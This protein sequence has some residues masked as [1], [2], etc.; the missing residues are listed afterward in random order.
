MPISQGTSYVFNWPA[1][2]KALL[3]EK[4]LREVTWQLVADQTGVH[5]TT[6]TRV[7]NSGKT[8]D[9]N[10]VL[11]LCK[12]MNRNPFD[13]ATRK[14]TAY[15]HVDSA[16]M[17]QIRMLAALLEGKGLAVEGEATVDTVIRLLNESA[18]RSGE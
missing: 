11:S 9:L 8:A 1:F 10:S 4:D 13:F 7:V 2:R 5:Y 17:R 14:R 18:E 16:G 3:A 12:W 15:K 6:F